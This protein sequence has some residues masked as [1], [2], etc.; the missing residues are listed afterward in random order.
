MGKSRARCRP[1]PPESARSRRSPELG[2]LAREAELAARIMDQ[3]YCS[4]VKIRFQSFFILI[5]VQFLDFALSMS[6]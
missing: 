6:A 4:N 3:C 1:E 5:T 2:H